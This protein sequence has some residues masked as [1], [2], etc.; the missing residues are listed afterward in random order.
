M[1]VNIAGFDCAFAASVFE[2]G[3][4]ACSIPPTHVFGSYTV[5]PRHDP[6]E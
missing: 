5:T 3:S 4:N 6:S 2:S 1:S